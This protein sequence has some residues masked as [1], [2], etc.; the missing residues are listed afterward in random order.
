VN[1]ERGNSLDSLFVLN[2]CKSR[3]VSSYDRSG[4][5]CDWITLA[6]GETALLADLYG[7]GIV[8]HIWCTVNAYLEDGTTTPHYLRKIVMRAWWDGETEPSIQAPIGDFFG[9][10]HAICKNFVSEP[11]SMNP[12][13]GRGFCCYFP[14]P[15]E[16]RARFTLENQSEGRMNF[17]YYIDYEEHASLAAGWGRFHAQYRQERDTL[18]WAPREAGWIKKETADPPYPA[19]LPKAWTIKNTD[20]KDNYL[21][22]D[23]RGKGKYVGCN[24]NIDVFERQANDWYGEGD[25][26]I[27]I[28]GEPWPPS[29][30][31]TGTEDY[32]NTAFCP[33]TEFCTPY[34]GITL[35]SGEQTGVPWSGKNSMYRFHIRDPV[36]FS[37][38]ILVTIEH[39]HANKLSND[40]S[41]TAYWYQEEPHMPFEPFPD[42]AIRLPR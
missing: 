13:E 6:A 12:K 28:D 26:M 21:I 11:L 32:F 4:G 33:R 22:L 42:T 10:G 19:W 40:Y 36:H 37:S 17:Y 3:R 39:G 9:M 25:D 7:C 14:M 41:S 20:G 15:F 29:L 1:L 2:S 31:G 38:S 34:Q 18:G 24:L 23:A 30:H 27:F 16:S 5:N 35:Y 8:R